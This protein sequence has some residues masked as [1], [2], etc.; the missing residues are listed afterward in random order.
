MTFLLFCVLSLS[1]PATA[2]AL[3]ALLLHL[4]LTAIE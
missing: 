3:S 4:W 2:L 1:L